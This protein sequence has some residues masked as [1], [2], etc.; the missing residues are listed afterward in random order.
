MTR[1][2]TLGTLMPQRPLTTNQPREDT[3][4]VQTATALPPRPSGP[5]LPPPPKLWMTPEEEEKHVAQTMAQVDSSDGDLPIRPTLGKFGIT[6]MI[7]N[8]PYGVRHAA[9]SLLTRYATQGCPVNC[10]EQ[11]SHIHLLACLQRGPHKSALDPKAIK[12]LREETQ[13]KIQQGFVRVVKWRDIKMAI[14]KNLKFSPVAMIPHKSK[15]FRCIVD[16]SF[17]LKHDGTTYPSVNSNTIPCA[18]SQAMT[19]LGSSL[20]RLLAT[21]VQNWNPAFPFYFAKLDIKDGFWRVKVRDEDAWHFT[22]VLPSITDQPTDEIELVVPN[23]LQMGWCESPALFCACSE[24]ARD[25]MASLVHRDLPPHPLE[26]YMFPDLP[27]AAGPPTSTTILEVYV[28]D[29]IGLT[30][31]AQPSHLLRLSRAM[32]QGAHA[33]SPPPSV[34]GHCGADPIAEKKLEKL[35][36]R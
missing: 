21:M 30:N 13:D 26:H 2:I 16:L 6:L 33:I 1:M 15:P 22:Y 35:D 14:P 3:P 10:G 12:Q 32:L 9:T 24:T 28:D 27:G 19:Q 29:F 36:G 11:W 31:N 17:S 4:A 25:I 23:S 8:K 7:P 34:T 18:P 20:P 5:P